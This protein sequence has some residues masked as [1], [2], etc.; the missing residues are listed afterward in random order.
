MIAFGDE[1]LD[2]PML[3]AA[4]TGVAMGNAIEELQRK[5]DFVTKT[6][7]EAGIAYALNKY[8]NIETENNAWYSFHLR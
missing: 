7:N 3:E 8:L 4:G 2:L 1:E 5:A 6:N